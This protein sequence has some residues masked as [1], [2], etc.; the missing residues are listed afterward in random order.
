MCFSLHDILVLFLPVEYTSKIWTLNFG[1]SCIIRLCL[2]IHKLN[3]INIDLWNLLFL[4]TKQII[5]SILLLQ[6]LHELSSLSFNKDNNNCRIQTN[7]IERIRNKIII[8]RYK[9]LLLVNKSS[10]IIEISHSRGLGWS[11]TSHNHE[12]VNRDSI[13]NNYWIKSLHYSN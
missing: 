3:V 13:V 7:T 2:C 6:V 11:W 5:F 10:R 8:I 4:K 1:T 12:Q 9:S